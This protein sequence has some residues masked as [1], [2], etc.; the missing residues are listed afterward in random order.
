MRHVKRRFVG[1]QR[2]AVRPRDGLTKNAG[3]AVRSNPIDCPVGRVAVVTIR[4]GEINGARLGHHQII[5]PLAKRGIGLEVLRHDRDL[6]VRRDLQNLSLPGRRQEDVVGIVNPKSS[7]S[8]LR[9]DRQILSGS[10]PFGP[11]GDPFKGP[12]R[13]EVESPLGIYGGTF[14]I[15]PTLI[16]RDQSGRDNGCC[17]RVTACRLLLLWSHWRT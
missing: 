16:G 9:G 8:L 14:S 10:F 7:G 3:A 15:T 17:R 6:L 1:A 4:V 12:A 13:R 5:G 11:G 2:N